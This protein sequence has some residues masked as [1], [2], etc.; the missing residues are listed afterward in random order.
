[1]ISITGI[2]RILALVLIA[3]ALLPRAAVTLPGSYAQ[4]HPAE[5]AQAW[6][7]TT[8]ARVDCGSRV[9]CE[10]HVNDDERSRTACDPY[11]SKADR[12]R[13]SVT[14]SRA[15]LDAARDLTERETMSRCQPALVIYPVGSPP[16]KP[17]PVTM[18]PAG[19]KTAKLALCANISVGMFPPTIVKIGIGSGDAARMEVSWKTNGTGPRETHS[20][21]MN[22]A[23]VTQL[24][25]AVNRSDFWRLP[26][27]L[28][29]S[30]AADG[31]YAN[32]EV[33]VP[34]WRNHVGDAIGDGDAVDSSTLVNALSEIIARHWKNVPGA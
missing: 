4:R 7:K 26:P 34:G 9:F 12:K 25:I 15:W 17:H 19:M 28:S 1:M 5:C 2:V 10:A 23:E 8:D 21:Q 18:L 32:V 3:E 33:T 27:A 24:L 11:I 14:I 6:A 31:E 30:G 13:P 22:P 29:H 16:P 20:V